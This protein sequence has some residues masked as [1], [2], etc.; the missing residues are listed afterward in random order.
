MNIVLINNGKEKILKYFLCHIDKVSTTFL[1]SQT[2][3]AENAFKNDETLNVFYKTIT[4][5]TCEI[6][7]NESAFENCEN[8]QAVVFSKENYSDNK[9]LDIKKMFST[10]DSSTDKNQNII[11]ALTIQHHAFK[12]C[13]NL[14][15]VVFPNFKSLSIEKEAFANCKNLRSILLLEDD[16]VSTTSNIGNIYIHE[17]AFLNCYDIN[18]ICKKDGKIARYARENNFRTIFLDD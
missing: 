8:L 12:E 10:A 9:D 7:L 18:F 14:H 5:G 6:K 17:E 15:T 1:C 11:D 13:G 3:I 4:D 16:S 2:E